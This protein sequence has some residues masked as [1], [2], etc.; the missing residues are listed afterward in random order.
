MTC[1][2]GLMEVGGIFAVPVHWRHSLPG[3]QVVICHLSCVLFKLV[4]MPSAFLFS[5]VSVLRL[6]LSCL[7]IYQH[8]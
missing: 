5:A 8:S 7:Y 2:C 3:V 4:G 6:M 1:S